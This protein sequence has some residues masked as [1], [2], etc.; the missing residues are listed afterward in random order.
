ME[1]QNVTLTNITAEDFAKLVAV[2][3]KAEIQSNYPLPTAAPQ[4]ERY[5][6]RKEAAQKLTISM[7]TLDRMTKS[8]DIKCYRIGLGGRRKL[9][10]YEDIITALD[11]VKGAA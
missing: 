6:T 8:G 3:V 10:K 4:E 9:Y 7:Q 1:I 5:L 11:K 2:A